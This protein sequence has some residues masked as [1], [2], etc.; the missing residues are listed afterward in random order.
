VDVKITWKPHTRFTYRALRA[1]QMVHCVQ[2]WSFAE[3][4]CTIWNCV[5]LFRM[6]CLFNF[7]NLHIRGFCKLCKNLMMQEPFFVQHTFSNILM[8][9]LNTIFC[10]HFYLKSGRGS[11]KRWP[12]KFLSMLKFLYFSL[13]LK[14]LRGGQLFR[15][16]FFYDW[17]TL[18]FHANTLEIFVL[19]KMFIRYSVIKIVL[20]Y[21]GVFIMIF[22]LRAVV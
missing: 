15:R 6:D 13:D 12:K 22:Y 8:L 11:S 18:F 2:L 9:A 1:L 19:Q 10:I 7:E 14:T 16:F 4:R 5:H 21:I 17:R 3:A 20:K